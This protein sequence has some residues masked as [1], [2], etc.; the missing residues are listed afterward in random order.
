MAAILKNMAAILNFTWVTG[1]SK[2]LVFLFFLVIWGGVFI[3]VWF[4][5]CVFL[6]KHSRCFILKIYHLKCS[7][8][9]QFILTAFID[10]RIDS[11]HRN[12][13]TSL[14]F[15]NGRQFVTMQS[16]HLNLLS[17]AGLG[18]FIIIRLLR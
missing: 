13:S 12:I 18:D 16:V 6:N 3:L 5:L 14:H 7:L 4:F 8:I 15:Q 11:R 10:F 17:V 1:F 9:E 2:K